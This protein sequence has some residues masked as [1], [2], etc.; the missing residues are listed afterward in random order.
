MRRPRPLHLSLLVAW[1]AIIGVLWWMGSHPALFMP[2]FSGLVSRNL[3]HMDSGGLEVR[4]ARIRLF[5]GVDLYGVSLT[6]PGLRG[7]LTLATAD[8]VEV[9]F[10]LGEVVR[11]AIHLKRV[12]VANPRI[13]VRSAAPDKAEAAGRG[14]DLKFPLVVVDQLDISGAGLTV[15]GPDGRLQERII[16]LDW[17]GSLDS[18]DELSLLIRRCGFQWPTHTTEIQ[19]LRGRLTVTRQGIATD[20]LWGRFND[21]EVDIS[22]S[23]SWGDSLDLAVSVKG[24]SISE[25]EALIDQNIG[26]KAR[27][28]VDATLRTRGDTLIYAGVFDGELEGYTMEGLRGRALILTDSVHIRDMTGL[29]NGASFSGGGDFDIRDADAVKY[30]LTGDVADVDLAKGL[31]PDT[32][33][34]PQ[35][36]GHGNLRIEHTDSPMWTRVTG[37]MRDGFIDILPFDTCELDVEATPDSV[38]FNAVTLNRD[39]LQIDLSGHTDSLEVFRGEVTAASNDLGTLPPSLGW[40]DLRGV[41]GAIGRLAGPV[42]ALTFTGRVAGNDLEVGDLVAGALDSRVVITHVLDAPGVRGTMTG[43]DLVVGGVPLGT[44]SGS[45]WADSLGNAA[46]DSFTT[47]L[48]DTLTRMAFATEV[49]GD[50]RRFVVP[51]FRV[52]LEGT[53]W[54]LPRAAHF[55]L[56]PSFFDLQQA[57]LVSQH[58]SL[59]VQ[60]RAEGDSLLTGDLQLENFDLSLLNPFVHSPQPL[61][62]RVTAAVTASGTPREPVV[63]VDGTLV[64]APFELARVDSLHVVGGFSAGVVDIEHLDLRTD[65]GQFTA[66]GSV[67]HP[68]AGIRDFWSGAELDLDVAIPDGDWAFLEQ[69]QLPALDRLAG[70]F[71]GNLHVGGRTDD[72]LCRG[73]LTSEP[74]NV[75]WLHLDRLTGDVWVDRQTL[76]LGNLQGNQ[77]RLAM[78]GRIEVPL[79]LDFLS[80]PVS[81][82]DGPFLMRLSIPEGSDLEPLARATNAFATCSGRGEGQ[83]TVAGTLEHPLYAG[84]IAIHDADFVLR[85]L[86]EVYHEVECTGVFSANTLR[87]EEIRGNEGLRGKFTGDGTVLFNGLMLESFVLRL[88]LDRFLVASIP[89]LAVVVSGQGGRMVGV[90]VGPDSLLVPR[91][92][93]DLQVDKAQYSGDFSEKPGAVDPME[94]TVAPDWLADLHLHA[95]PRVAHISN[96]DMELDMGGDL[97]L[98]RDEA[99]LN[100]RGALDIN[101]G[102]LIV[103]NNS[104][105]VLRGR[106]D[107][108]RELGFDP[109][110]D[111]EAQATYRLRSKY[112]SNSVIEHIGV[113]ITGSLFQPQ[114]SFSSERGY[115]REAIQRMLLGLQPEATPEGDR[116]RLANSSITAGFNLLEREI[117]QELNVFDTFEIDQIQR[118]RETGGTG[119]DPLI[120][121]GKYIGSDLYLKY[122]QGVRQNDRDVLVEYQ[123]NNH[124]LLQSEIRRRIDENQGEPTYNLDL[125]YRFEY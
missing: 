55:T 45:G 74:F 23:R 82:L 58:G 72:P 30:V 108:S 67:A 53:V 4:D 96:R 121:V 66:Q 114:I 5:E 90:K 31:V 41:G 107:F 117:A 65:Y 59:L 9:D 116:G 14:E 6:M 36:G 97:D 68:G 93:G 1:L 20:R 62:G 35:T 40:P 11:R 69:F 16:D 15:T 79:Q 18:R 56:G 73:S 52:D 111:I 48:G 22:G 77:D 115:S 19:D 71:A 123:I 70:R 95:E 92:E 100:L 2:Y 119:L 12:T 124:F 25:I 13:F 57:T 85:D 89:E 29:I 26:F 27:G 125:K 50:L 39:R 32:D 37:S 44:F 63:D 122:A 88:D 80:E 99:G 7:A 8:T 112:S 60:G 21:H 24:A 105:E 94:A 38:T 101:K 78:T 102:R 33:G 64:Q 10:A 110:V 34:L 109:R 28:D 81:P 104:F 75:H 120:G 83:V 42:D 51:R 3:L 84:S 47:A 49:S 46:M 118:E 43:R 113:Q 103:F 76:V 106:L 86:E 54:S 91:F 98:I 17:R 87:I 61:S